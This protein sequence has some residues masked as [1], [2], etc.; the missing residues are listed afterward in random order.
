MFYRKIAVAAA[1]AL[2]AC[3][4]NTQEPV[5]T[6]PV[7][8]NGEVGQTFELKAGQTAQVGSLLVL[9]RGVPQD[10]RCPSDVQCVW[11]GDATLRVEL[12]V[13]RMAWT[14]YELHTGVDPR[15]AKFRENTITVVDLKPATR[16]SSTI[17]PE[18]YIATF[19]VD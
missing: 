10:S 18:D 7:V 2:G 11:A 6:N 16:S 1:L 12:T 3:S 19:R 15:S 5:N 17:R 13:G 8:V 9:F 4:S 14:P